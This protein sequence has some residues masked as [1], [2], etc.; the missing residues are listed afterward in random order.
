VRRRRLTFLNE[1][2]L[3]SLANLALR[4]ESHGETGVFVEA[5]CALGGS[6]ILLC[7]AKTPDRRL[8]VHDVF[9]MIPPPGENDGADVHARYSVIASGRA[10]GHGGDVYYGYQ[11]DLRATVEHNFKKLGF[12]I[13]KSNVSLVEGLVQ[14]TLTP[15]APVCL[16]HVDVDWYDPV[17]TCLERIVPKLAPRGAIVLDDYDQWSG[18]RRATDEYFERVGKSGFD[19]DDSAGHLVVRRRPA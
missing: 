3:Q 14:D 12:P 4:I 7:A 2:R 18:C 8:Y 10:R 5:G 9:S 15:T 19:F 11:S 17:L 1:Q 6:S 16:A 13:D